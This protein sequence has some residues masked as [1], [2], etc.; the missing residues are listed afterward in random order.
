MRVQVSLGQGTCDPARIYVSS[1]VLSNNPYIWLCWRR[2]GFPCILELDISF[3]WSLFGNWR[4][5]SQCCN[6]TPMLYSGLDLELS[7]P[8]WRKVGKSQRS[9]RLGLQLDTGVLCNFYAQDRTPTNTINEITVRWIIWKQKKIMNLIYMVCI[10]PIGKLSKEHQSNGK[11]KWHL[12]F[13]KDLISCISNFK[14]CYASTCKLPKNLKRNYCHIILMQKG[15]N[16]KDFA[17]FGCT[18]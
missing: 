16:F 1:S 4:D 7:E 2:W 6:A 3:S 9:H 13:L 11:I 8:I 15:R 17:W 18:K 12:D 10:R 14:N 5:H